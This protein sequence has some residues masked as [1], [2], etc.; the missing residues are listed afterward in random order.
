MAI[1][2]VRPDTKAKIND[3]KVGCI[4]FCAPLQTCIQASRPGRQ[5]GLSPHG[6]WAATPFDTVTIDITIGSLIN[7][8]PVPPLITRRR[9][10]L[11]PLFFGRNLGQK[12]R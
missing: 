9:L 2:E 1:N 7:T 8:I 4:G 12:T 10:P 5:T 11:P 6:V 3:G